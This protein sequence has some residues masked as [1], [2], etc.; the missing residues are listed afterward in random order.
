MNILK[1]I[2][3][4]AL[5]T[6]GVLTTEIYSKSIRMFIEENN[7]IYTSDIER[8]VFGSP[9]AAGGHIMSVICK[10]SQTPEETIFNFLEFHKRRVS[11]IPAQLSDGVLDF[12]KLLKKFNARVTSYGGSDKSISFDP[13]LNSLSSYFDTNLP[14]INIGNSRPGMSKIINEFHCDP[15]EVLFIDDLNRVADIAHIL[16]AGF[17]GI[18]SGFFQKEQMMKS[19]VSLIVD[20]L[21]EINESAIFEVDRKLSETSNIK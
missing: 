16:G 5:D 9:H 15:C 14:Y 3:V 21:E 6:N 19:G 7:G 1:K 10:L 20:S 2:K 13:Y 11:G 12:L 18:P 17:I 4:I 8:L